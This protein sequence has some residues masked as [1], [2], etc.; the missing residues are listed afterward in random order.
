[1]NSIRSNLDRDINSARIIPLHNS[2]PGYSRQGYHTKIALPDSNSLRLV[3]LNEI[4]YGQADNNYTCV[5]LAGGTDLLVS[6][7]LG[8]IYDHLEQS[9]MFLRVHQSW[10]VR[11]ESIKV[12]SHDKVT[13]DCGTQI[14]LARNRRSEVKQQVLKNATCLS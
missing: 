10:F 1:M 6:K 7:N 2:T 3:A 8:Y 12:L 11:T 9:R 5:H 14:P 4:Q 13:L